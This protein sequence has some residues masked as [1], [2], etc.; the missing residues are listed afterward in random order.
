MGRPKDENS[1]ARRYTA[2]NTEQMHFYTN[3]VK[4]LLLFLL[5]GFDFLIFRVKC[6]SPRMYMPSSNLLKLNW[7]PYL[8][9]RSLE[10]GFS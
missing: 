7:K 2:K 3:T 5:S 8:E 1:P 6:Y 4:Q 9:V 10:K